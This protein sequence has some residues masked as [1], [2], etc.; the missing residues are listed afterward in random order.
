[1]LDQFGRIV[2][3]GS[4]HALPVD[5]RAST[6]PFPQYRSEDVSPA[7][8]VV[9]SEP[10]SPVGSASTNLPS[11]LLQPT[12]P[13][14]EVERRPNRIGSSLNTLSDTTSD[15]ASDRSNWKTTYDMINAA[16]T[17]T[18]ENSD[19]VL[20]LTAVVGAISAVVEYHDVSASY[21]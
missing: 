16:V 10:P 13:D 18:K 20:P 9:A 3:W 5:P 7:W 14:E 8:E 21:S 17:I 4:V 2:G 6:N 19:L 15:G 1:M 12:A 11:E